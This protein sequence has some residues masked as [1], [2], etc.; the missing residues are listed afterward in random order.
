MKRHEKAKPEWLFGVYRP[1]FEIGKL[2]N[3]M[4]DGLSR[5]KAKLLALIA[6][7]D[8]KERL[9]ALRKHGKE[10]GIYKPFQTHLWDI[11]EEPK[12]QISMVNL[13]CRCKT[14]ADTKPA[15]DVTSGL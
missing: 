13:R 9:N 2:A 12:G 14:P 7:D 3:M 10:S 5:D 4:K 15:G 11:M 8:P 1:Q 6:T